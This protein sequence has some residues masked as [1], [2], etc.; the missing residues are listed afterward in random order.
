MLD[1]PEAATLQRSHGEAKVAIAMRGG[2]AA[3]SGLYQ[4]GSAKGAEAI[5]S[6]FSAVSHS[7]MR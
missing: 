2:R 1:G 5:F 6:A 4:R 7:E 3:L